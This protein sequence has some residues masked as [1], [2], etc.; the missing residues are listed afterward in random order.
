LVSRPRI[1]IASPDPREC[2]AAADWLR[3]EGFEPIPRPT[4]GAALEE[5]QLRSFD[6]LVADEVFAFRSGLHAAS[7][8]RRPLTPT[9][10]VGNTAVSTQ[11]ESLHHQVM[12]LERPIDRALLVC[13]ASLALADARPVRCSPRK[14]AHRFN[15]IVHGFRSYIIDV[16]PEGVRLELPRDR[17]L[18]LPPFFNAQV[19]LLGIAVTVQRMWARTSLDNGTPV[20]WCGGSLA[21][22]P[23]RAATAWRSFVDTIPSVSGPLR[24]TGLRSS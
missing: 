13:T 3:A 1:V 19:P 11:T 18:V 15:A 21:H 22:N 17:R 8:A 7:R 9:I 4:A 14:P 20:L 23:P 2:A 6:L 24:D 16:S 12:Y 5:L 10:I